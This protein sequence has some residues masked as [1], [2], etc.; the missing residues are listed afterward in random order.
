MVMQQ[1]IPLTQDLVLIGGGHAHALV[2]RRWAMRPQAGVR[3]TLVNPAPTAAYTGMLPGL[4]AGHYARHDV[5]IDLVRLCRFAGARLIVDAAT[6]IDR[7][8]RLIHLQNRPP[9]RYDVASLDVGVGAAPGLPHVTPARPL[10]PFAD[11][12]QAFLDRHIESPAIVVLGGGVAGMELALAARHCTGAHVTVVDRGQALAALGPRARRAVLHHAHALTI[13]ENDA[14]VATTPTAVHLATGRILPADFTI[15]VAGAAP[16]PWLQTLGLTLHDGS[17]AVSPTLQSSDPLIFAAGDCC[18]L[19]HAPRP[20]AGVFAVRAAPVL[21][22]NLRAALAGLALQAFHPQRDYLKI[23]SMGAQNAVAERSGLV[24]RGAWLWRVKDRID[25]A[26]MD[27][28]SHFPAMPR[29]VLPHDVALGVLQAMGDK[30]MC[31]GCGA[32]VGAVTLATALAHLP[33]H[34]RADVLAGAGDDAA[35]LSIGAQQ[36]VITTD[37]LRTFVCDPYVMARIAAQHALGDI[38]AMGAEPQAVLAQITL[39][40]LGARLQADMLA[41]ILAAAAAVF[42]EAGADVVGGHTTVGTELTIGFTITGLVD[43]PVRKGGARAGDVLILTKPVGSGTIMAADMA[44][45][46][47]PGLVLG[48]AVQTALAT[49][50]RSLGPAAAILAPVATAMTDVTGFGLAGHLLEMLQASGCGATLTLADIPFMPGA[51]AL[52]AAGIASTLAPDNRAAVSWQMDVTD[53]P[54][55]ALLYDPQTAGGLLAAVPATQAER[56]LSALLAAG[57]QAA[58]IGHIVAGD[59]RVRVV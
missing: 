53:T 37:H 25:R 8:A 18:H 39:P 16:L 57:E 54:H 41:E 20:K 27:K 32:K 51:A 56:V 24:L 2:L 34:R 45:A 6:G 46:H 3:L 33:L 10:G 49:M 48:E 21:H 59:V 43:R 40:A 1:P 36:Q 35:V 15:G 19:T 11:A 26:F 17:V 23:I 13:I 5:M 9:L 55:A 58:A 12:W 31:G 30:S 14:A 52:A 7:T 42:A 4:I 28:L 29:P 47:V 22:H 38:W 50:Q 44:M